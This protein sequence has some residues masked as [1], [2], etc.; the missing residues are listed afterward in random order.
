MD[1]LLLAI[2]EFNTVEGTLSLVGILNCSW[3]DASLVWTPSSYGGLSSINVPQSDI[4]IPDL[5]I[6]NQAEKFTPFGKSLDTKL[7]VSHF[8]LVTWYPG[9][10][11]KVKCSPNLE[12][13]PFDRQS[14]SIQVVAFGSSSTEVMFVISQTTV[15]TDFFATNKEWTLDSSSLEV[16]SKGQVTV[17]LNIKR[18]W[19]YFTVTVLIPIYVIGLLIPL[20]FLLPVDSGERVS[21]STSIFLSFTVVLTLVNS[22]IP[23]LSDPIPAIM[24][25]IAVLTI[26]SGVTVV[27]NVAI[28]TYYFSPG[29]EVL[30]PCLKRFVCVFVTSNKINDNETSNEN[31]KQ[32]VND[33]IRK[34]DV[35]KRLNTVFF[36]GAYFVIIVLSAS[37]TIGTRFL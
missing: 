28:L 16:E 9:N 15:N 11:M 27:I 13:F 23:S 25:Y 7:S 10:V 24:L 20:V 26:I 32:R 34:I 2:N 19:L 12:N 17:T 1:F 21:F 33:T 3:T 31:A 18:S 36:I 37:F 4:W 29:E 5:F 22:E 14:C 30:S 8:G 35:V 6:I